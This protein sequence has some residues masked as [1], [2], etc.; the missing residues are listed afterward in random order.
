MDNK[1]SSVYECFLLFLTFLRHHVHMYT[2]MRTHVYTHLD[3]AFHIRL[4]EYVHED[5]STL[6]S[7]VL[8]NVKF[9]I[10]QLEE[11]WTQSMAICNSL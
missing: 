7:E 6:K 10:I 3:V 9:P 4:Q 5:I 11:T 8:Y 2:N 1:Y